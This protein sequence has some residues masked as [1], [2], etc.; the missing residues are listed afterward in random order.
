MR[1]S[2]RLYARLL[3]SAATRFAR[4]PAVSL[5][6]RTVGGPELLM[7]PTRHGPVRCWVTRPAPDAPLAEGGVVRPPVHLNFHG[8]AFIV[9]APRQDEHL[10]RAFAGEAGVVVVNVDYSAGTSVRYPRAHE[11]GFDVL[12]WVREAGAD[13]GWDAERISLSGTSAGANLAL[14]VLEL[15]RRTGAPSIAATA[16][17]VPPVDQTIPPEAYVAPPGS[18]EKPFVNPRLARILHGHYF[19][20]AARRSEPLASPAL[21]R[22][23]QLASL[24]P[25]LVF[26]AERDSLRPPIERYVERLRAAGVDIEYRCMPGVDHGYTN[27]PGKDGVPALRQT[28]Q[29][30]SQFLVRHHS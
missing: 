25:L 14:G 28:A 13:L 16:L 6:E 30:I 29:L 1:I 5:T 11:E 12:R 27:Q 26:A 4:A 17:I 19:A 10:V 23:E 9:G 20:D 21:A 18:T 2:D 7:V 3:S 15:V 8:G 24:P 22:R